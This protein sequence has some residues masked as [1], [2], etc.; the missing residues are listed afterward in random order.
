MN[1]SELAEA[2]ELGLSTVVD[3]ERERR[4]VSKQAIFA[5]RKVFEEAGIEFLGEEGGGEGFR[6]RAVRKPKRTRKGA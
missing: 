5:M 1:Q 4:R 2:A 6:Y 3:F